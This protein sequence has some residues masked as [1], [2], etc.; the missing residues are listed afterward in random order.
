[1][2]VEITNYPLS[3]IEN[4][5]EEGRCVVLGLPKL[6]SVYSTHDDSSGATESQREDPGGGMSTPPGQALGKWH[7]KGKYVSAVRGHHQRQGRDRWNQQIGSE[8]TGDRRRETASQQD[9]RRTYTAESGAGRGRR[10]QEVAGR[11]PCGSPSSPE[12][13]SRSRFSGGTCNGGDGTDQET[14]GGGLGASRSMRAG[15]K[16]RLL[17]DIRRTRAMWKRW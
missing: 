11:G 17:G 12:Q 6:Y 1:M 8:V 10:S 14:V 3:H 16:R 7:G 9:G 15:Q 5:E 2:S 4:A 13:S